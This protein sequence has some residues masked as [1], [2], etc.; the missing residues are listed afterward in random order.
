M[1]ISSPIK[2]MV[3]LRRC[4][5]TLAVWS[6]SLWLYMKYHRSFVPIKHL[7]EFSLISAPPLATPPSEKYSSLKARRCGLTWHQVKSTLT[8]ELTCEQPAHCHTHTWP[9]A[10]SNR[11]FL[12]RVMSTSQKEE[13]LEAVPKLVR[14][15]P[16]DISY[17][18]IE[19]WTPGADQV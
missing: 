2:V 13:W 18:G 10:K 17:S 7:V 9:G 3:F 5:E 15:L 16:N 12:P 4:I 11:T 1:S 8:C 19:K 6:L 14:I